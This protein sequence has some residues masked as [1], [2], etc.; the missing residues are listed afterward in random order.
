VH[1]ALRIAALR[2]LGCSGYLPAEALTLVR[3]VLVEGWLRSGC[4]WL[5][6]WCA[7]GELLLI[8]TS[9][10]GV[11]QEPSANMHTTPCA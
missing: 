4:L 11:V 8:W 2:R 6:V 10:G 3:R 7:G 9:E 5:G 1:E